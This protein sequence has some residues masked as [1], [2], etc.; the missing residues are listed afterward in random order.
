MSIRPECCGSHARHASVLLK[1]SMSLFDTIGTYDNLDE[2][3]PFFNNK[4]VIYGF[5]ITFLVSK[6]KRKKKK[7]CPGP[8]P[9]TYIISSRLQHSNPLTSGGVNLHTLQQTITTLCASLRLYV[10]F[11][12]TRCPGWDDYFIVVIL[13]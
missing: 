2:P 9:K 8:R 12:V 13:V 6:T 4:S 10:R 1:L 11:W 5:I 7:T 3:T